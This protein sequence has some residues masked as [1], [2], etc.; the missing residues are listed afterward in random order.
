M[1]LARKY[2][3]ISTRLLQRLKTITPSADRSLS[4]YP[5]VVTL[6]DG[7]TQDRVYLVER[8]LY[9]NMWGVFPE[10]DSGK[11]QVY[12]QDVVDI[13]E[14]PTR[15]P[16]RFANSL[17]MAGESCMG[18]VFYQLVFADGERLSVLTGNAIDFLPGLGGRSPADIDDVIPHEG[19]LDPARVPGPD[20]AWCIYDGVE[21]R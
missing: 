12:V 4:Y 15:M 21:S 9:I 17:Y 11:S 1:D 3:P 6:R 14:S 2:Q 7:T 5:C 13:A 19:R 10:D 20:Y 18:G 8:G 16:V